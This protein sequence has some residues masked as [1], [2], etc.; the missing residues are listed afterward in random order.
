MRKVGQNKATARRTANEK[1]AGKMDG[2]R[3]A[4]SPQSLRVFPLSLPSSR[5]SPLSERLEQASRSERKED[6]N[7]EK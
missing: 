2:Q 7:K 6:K 5:L 4:P 1:D 3:G